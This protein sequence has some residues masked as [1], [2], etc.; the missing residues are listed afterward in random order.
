MHCICTGSIIDVECEATFH[1][2]SEAI[3]RAQYTVYSIMAAALAD[4]SAEV[5][6]DEPDADPWF[7][8]WAAFEETAQSYWDWLVA[9]GYE[10]DDLESGL[11]E[12]I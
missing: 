8:Q 7:I 12:L 11:D 9:N 3:V 1:N 6:A 10:V 4:S 2:G 5:D